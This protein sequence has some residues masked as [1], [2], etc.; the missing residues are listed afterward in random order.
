MMD[1]D[2]SGVDLIMIFLTRC[3]KIPLQAV[4]RQPVH[5]QMFSLIVSLKKSKMIVHHK[6]QVPLQQCHP[7]TNQV[8]WKVL[9]CRRA[10]FRLAHFC[11]HNVNI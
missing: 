9:S 4:I 1:W 8:L 7:R 10:F 6:A 5:C 3:R 11:P 2:K